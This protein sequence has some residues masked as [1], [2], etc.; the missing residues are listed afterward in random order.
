MGPAPRDSSS[1]WALPHWNR[2]LRHT[3]FN[4][5]LSNP[6]PHFE[7]RLFLGI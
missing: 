4:A 2:P 6:E 7:N 3:S 5:F 1:S